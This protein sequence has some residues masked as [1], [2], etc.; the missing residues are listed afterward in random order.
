MK[1]ALICLLIFALTAPPTW[2]SP[3]PNPGHIESIKKKVA[4]CINHQRRVVVETYDNRQILG[5][6]SEA[7]A[8]DFVLSYAGKPTT[9]AYREVKKIK[10][11]SP[12]KKEIEAFAGAAAIA[13]ALLGLVALLGGLR[14]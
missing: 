2:A 5:F 12:M 14:G 4:D 10:W 3:D 13:G 11:P 6:I 7:R 9:L 1:N 8:D